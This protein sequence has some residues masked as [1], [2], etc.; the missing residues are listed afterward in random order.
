VRGQPGFP[1]KDY[2]LCFR[3][4]GAREPWQSFA[5]T[6]LLIIQLRVHH[7]RKEQELK[8]WRGLKKQWGT[9]KGRG[10]DEEREETG[11]LSE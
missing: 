9:G 4:K 10:S 3:C 7:R 11:H 8:A 1:R 5:L 2:R 6:Q